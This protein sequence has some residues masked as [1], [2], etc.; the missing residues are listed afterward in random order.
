MAAVK[1]WAARCAAGLLALAAARPAAAVVTQDSGSCVDQTV[2]ADL[3]AKRRRR[4]VKERLFQKTNRHELTVRGGA[5]V[6]DLFDGAPVVGAGYTYHLTER[7]GVEASAAWTRYASGP[8]RELED[9]FALLAGERRDSW[10]FATDL[11]FSPVYAKF[12]T[13]GSVVHFD[14]LFAAGA[15]VVDSALSSGVAGNAGVGFAFFLGQALALR[16]DVRDYVYRQELLAKTLWVNDLAATLG[17]S[18]FLPW[19]P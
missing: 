3:D 11:V 14:V 9:R 8:V 1:A 12:Q 15:G 4:S 19:E 6:S 16:F 7:F 2:K 5:Y 13:G 17:V 18:V 10:L